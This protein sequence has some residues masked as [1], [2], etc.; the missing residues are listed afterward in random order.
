LD[1]SILAACEGDAVKRP[2][3]LVLFCHG[4]DPSCHPYGDPPEN[5]MQPGRFSLA[6]TSSRTT[7]TFTWWVSGL[8]ADPQGWTYASYITVYDRNGDKK[9]TELD[10]N[11]TA[12]WEMTPSP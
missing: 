11:T 12:V 2:A 9:V 7:A 1:W 6:A 3:L 5:V 4:Y 10:G 8:E